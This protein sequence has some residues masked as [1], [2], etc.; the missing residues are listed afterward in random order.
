MSIQIRIDVHLKF[1]LIF[2]Y[3]LHYWYNLSNNITWLVS[4]LINCN[5]RTSIL[6]QKTRIMMV[7]FFLNDVLFY[8]I[9]TNFFLCTYYRELTIFACCESACYLKSKSRFCIINTGPLFP[10]FNLALKMA[11]CPQQI[12][13]S[14]FWQMAV[15]FDRWRCN[16]S[17]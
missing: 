8:N 6:R 4:E 10:T 11:N 1:Y 5:C 9:A 2:H 14:I 17:R 3:F 12:Q 15:V 7:I 13:L 16:E